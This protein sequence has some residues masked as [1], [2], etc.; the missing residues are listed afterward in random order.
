[1]LFASV[2]FVLPV[3]A[4]LVRTQ[5]DHAV[6]VPDDGMEIASAAPESAALA[7]LGGTVELAAGPGRYR[8]E[9]KA[10]IPHR[11]VPDP[12]EAIRV[13]N[14]LEELPDMGNP[15]YWAKRVMGY[16]TVE[17][18]YHSHYHGDGHQDWD[19]SHRLFCFVEFDYD[20]HTITEFGPADCDPGVTTREWSWKRFVH[21]PPRTDLVV[22]TGH[23]SESKEAEPSFSTGVDH[24]TSRSFEMNMAASNA[25]TIAPAPTAD[26]QIVGTFH[27]PHLNLRYTTDRF[28]N[29]GLRVLKDGQEVKRAKLRDV[30]GMDMTGMTGVF[31]IGYNLVRN[32]NTGT[33]TL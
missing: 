26:A 16:P 25:L 20:G 4:K 27:G 11:Q 22:A 1:M 2:V 10:W 17:Y 18:E 29:Y 24:V 19:G 33:V 32:N 30:G 13:S 21:R 28:P 12:E 8:V 31:N 15:T 23:D 5:T 7:D 9:A 3:A 14:W 6:P